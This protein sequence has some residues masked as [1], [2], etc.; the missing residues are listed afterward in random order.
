MKTQ[1]TLFLAFLV[2]SLSA[3]IPEGYYETTAGLDGEEL[4]TELHE[5][6]NDHV[7]FTYTS[8]NTDTWD[9]LKQTD[10]DPEDE[11]YVI[12][13]YSGFKM[14][15]SEEY[16]NGD[17]WNREH[18]WAKSRGS[19]GTNRGP[20]TDVHNLRAADISTNSA[21]NNRN[22]DEATVQYID[23][24]GQYQGETESYTSSSEWIWEP[25]DKVKG[26]VARIL[27][28]MA[29][30]Y[31]GT[32]GEPDLELREELL[33]ND[34]NE[35]Y[36]ARLSALLEWHEADPVD[37]IE[38][39]RNNVI[40]SFQENR[41]PFIDHPAFV[42]LIWGGEKADDVEDEEILSSD[43]KIKNEFKFYPN[44]VTSNF[45]IDAPEGSK[46][47]IV[48]SQGLGIYKNLKRAKAIDKIRKLPNGIYMLITRYE[49]IIISYQ[50]IKNE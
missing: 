49:N 30:R 13:F 12:G 3:Q 48:N 34:S 35:P 14:D 6:I 44:P 23:E 27:F 38:R 15:A 20:G 36:H 50:I 18:V 5:I 33:S 40:Y 19:L 29:T 11:S 9:I 7:I 22:F 26:D 2:F 41:N 31:E 21:R 39:E 8:S 47:N 43:E 32:S 4:K 28:Y 46:F 24:S 1:L 10:K 16:N 45:T 17:G 37:E 25:R 42:G